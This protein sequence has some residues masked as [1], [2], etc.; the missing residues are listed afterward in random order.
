MNQPL[1]THLLLTLILTF[2]ISNEAKSTCS[3]IN[4]AK[5]ASMTIQP[6]NKTRLPNETGYA[7]KSEVL[8]AKQLAPLFGVSSAFLPIVACTAGEE[9]IIG[10]SSFVA[11]AEVLKTN[12]SGVYLNAQGQKA[13][14][15]QYPKNGGNDTMIL[16]SNGSFTAGFL[17]SGANGSAANVIGHTILSGKMLQGGAVKDGL[18]LNISTSDGLDVMD[19]FISSFTVDI[20][21]CTVNDYDKTLDLGTVYTQQMNSPGST[22]VAKDFNINMTCSSTQLSPTLTFNGETES[23]LP[24][25]LSNNLGGSKGVGVQLLYEGKIITPGTAISLGRVSATY[26]KDYI[27]QAR[28]YQTLSSV[29]AGG[30]EFTTTFTVEYE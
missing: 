8:S 21:A 2:S 26:A 17:T 18:V 13:S 9:L 1:L 14:I 22:S 28:M 23:N 25:V 29:T 19:V 27:F 10:N 4:G 24:S 12:I 20:P 11:D 7:A 5:K 30:V 16:P 15:W 3:F 6:E